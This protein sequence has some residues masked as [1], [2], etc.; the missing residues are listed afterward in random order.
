M[1]ATSRCGRRTLRLVAA[2]LPLLLVGCT[3]AYSGPDGMRVV[4][5]PNAIYMV[6]Q[7]PVA[8]QH[9]AEVGPVLRQQRQQPVVEIV[10]ALGVADDPFVGAQWASRQRLAARLMIELCGARLVPDSDSDVKLVAGT[11]TNDVWVGS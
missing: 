4:V 2:A 8:A 5:K 3:S 9:L 10:Q 1:N 11:N 6:V 7:G